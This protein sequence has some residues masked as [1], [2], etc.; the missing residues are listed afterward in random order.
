MARKFKSAHS[1]KIR[2]SADMRICGNAEREGC[3]AEVDRE[4]NGGTLKWAKSYTA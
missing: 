1:L 3:M 2:K 4:V